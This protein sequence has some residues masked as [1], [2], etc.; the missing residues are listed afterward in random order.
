MVEARAVGPA[1]PPSRRSRD[2]WA[3]VKDGD[4]EEAAYALDSGADVNWSNP[5]EGHYTPLMLSASLC[6][7]DVTRFLLERGADVNGASRLGNTALMVA[8]RTGSSRSVGI[9]ELLLEHGAPR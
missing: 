2:L 8:A 4:V 7:E 9:C 1:P 6:F 3:A 5:E